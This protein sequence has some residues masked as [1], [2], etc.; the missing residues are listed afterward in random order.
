LP[1]VYEAVLL[2]G[3]PLQEELVKK[4]KVTLAP[5]ERRQLRELI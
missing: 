4:Y 1:V 5:E 3:L 2:K